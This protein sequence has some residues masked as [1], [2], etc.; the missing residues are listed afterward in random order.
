LAEGNK[1]LR[2]GDYA[3]AIDCYAQVIIQTPEL[4]KAIAISS[5]LTLAQRKYRADRQGLGKPISHA[6]GLENIEDY[7]TKS[8]IKGHIDRL[9]DGF[10]IGWATNLNDFSRNL[11]VDVYIP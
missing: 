5:N 8:N 7:Q 9:Q 3:K 10:I 2:Q 4:G 11:D 1:S 6:Y